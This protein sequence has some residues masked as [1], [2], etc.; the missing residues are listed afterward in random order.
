MSSLIV[1]NLFIFVLAIVLAIL[2]I[3]IEGAHGWAKNLPTWRP[4]SHKW[5]VKLYSKIMSGKELTGYHLTIFTFVLLIFN[6]PYVFS[7]PLTL[8]N[9]LKTLSFFFMF[10]V[11]WDFLWF[12]LNP[13]YPLKHFTGEHVWWHEKWLFKL[14][15]DYYGGVITSLVILLPVYFWIGDMTI[16]SW[17]LSNLLLF[18]VETLLIIAFSLFVLR[19]DNWKESS[20]K[21]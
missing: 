19:I 5:Y 6:L 20:T 14:P 17:W 12:V 21:S 15:V 10:I 13:F 16:L 11:L 3:Q 18:I 1:T 2:E 9:Y 7:L 8:E 4:P